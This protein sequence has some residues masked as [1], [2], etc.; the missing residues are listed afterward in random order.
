MKGNYTLRASAA[1]NHA[2]NKASRR[3]KLGEG[4][5]SVIRQEMRLSA[6]PERLS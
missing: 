1:K 3:L 6:G 2:L 4:A 5:C